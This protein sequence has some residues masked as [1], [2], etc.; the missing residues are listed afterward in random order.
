[1][2]W[3]AVGEPAQTQDTNASLTLKGDTIALAYYE[4]KERIPDPSAGPLNITVSASA[5][6]VC[7]QSFSHELTVSWAVSGG[8]RPAAAQIEIT[9]PNGQVG[10]FGV[11]PLSGS[12]IFPLSF[13]EGGRVNIKAIATDWT[14]SSSSQESSVEL[15][16]CPPVPT[17]GSISG[18]KFNDRDRD[19]IRDIGEEGLAGWRIKLQGYDTLTGTIVNR[20]EITDASGNYRFMDVTPGFYV[21]YEIVKSGGWV[22]TTPVAKS[23]NLK[24]NETINV[25]FGNKKIP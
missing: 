8:Q 23:I 15:K 5:E 11:K 12:Q 20:E 17:A 14:N 7:I 25:N 9:N 2:G 1:M 18:M 19:G 24:A 22:P 6:P 16:A 21:V 13:L 4:L 10:T 3:A